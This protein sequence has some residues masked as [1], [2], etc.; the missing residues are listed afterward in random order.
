[1]IFNGGPAF[2]NPGTYYIKNN[3][4]MEIRP[5]FNGMSMRNWFAGM[6]LQGLV[7][8]VRAEGLSTSEVVAIAYEYADDM[9]KR[10]K[11]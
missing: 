3:E 4:P 7:G 5:P 6:A 11:E 1:M 8:S 10:G 2:P 9:L